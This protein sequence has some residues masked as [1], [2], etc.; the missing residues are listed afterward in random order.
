M[1]NNTRIHDYYESK[2]IKLTLLSKLTRCMLPFHP[3]RF[4]VSVCREIPC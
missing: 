2:F 4:Y 3:N 1:L